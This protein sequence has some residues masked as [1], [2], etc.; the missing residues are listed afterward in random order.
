LNYPLNENSEIA[1]ENLTRLA[2][3]SSIEPFIP[4]VNQ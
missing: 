4:T 1:W 2:E 3:D